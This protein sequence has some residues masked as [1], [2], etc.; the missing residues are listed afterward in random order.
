MQENQN[1]NNEVE[2][3]DLNHLMQ[4]RRDKLKDLQEQGKNPF[5]ITKFNRTNT[6]GKIKSNY[7]KIRKNKIHRN[8][9]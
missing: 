6:A 8:K 2:E 5:E 9:L 1:N 7:E 3:L 4:I